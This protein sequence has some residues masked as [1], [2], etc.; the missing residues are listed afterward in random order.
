M[1]KYGHTCQSADGTCGF[2]PEG[3]VVSYVL[4]LYHKT[5]IFQ[6]LIPA[7]STKF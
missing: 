2:Y 1:F 6:G 4:L 5:Q 3:P 7:Q